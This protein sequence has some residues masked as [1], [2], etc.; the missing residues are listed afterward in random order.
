MLVFFSMEREPKERDLFL[1][2]IEGLTDAQVISRKATL[3]KILEGL[4]LFGEEDR[5]RHLLSISREHSQP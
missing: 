5:A 3:P 1:K 2:S 4:T